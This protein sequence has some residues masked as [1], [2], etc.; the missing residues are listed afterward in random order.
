MSAAPGKVE[1]QGV[2]EIA[3][4][5]VFA[6]RFIQGRNS[7]WVQR[8]FFA[9]YDPDATWLNDLKPA[10]SE[11]KFFYEDEYKIICDENNY[12]PLTKKP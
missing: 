6:L 12:K 10:F 7:D 2:C 11:S 5:K 4:E 3:G 8:P 1:I 9:K